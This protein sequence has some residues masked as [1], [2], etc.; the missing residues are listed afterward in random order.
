MQQFIFKDVPEGFFKAK[1]SEIKEENGKYGSYLRFIFTIIDEGELKYYRFSGIVQS[2]CL[3]QSKFYRWITNILG[4]H[5]DSNF[6]TEDLLG[7]ECLVFIAKKNNYYS[8][9]D[10]SMKPEE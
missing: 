8:V 9:V 5:P 1:L 7:E 3:K 6:S 10:V 2:T 4:Q